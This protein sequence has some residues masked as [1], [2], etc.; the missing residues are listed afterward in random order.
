MGTEAGLRTL[1]PQPPWAASLCCSLTPHPSLNPC[2]NPRTQTVLAG[3]EATDSLLSLTPISHVFLFAPAQS[4]QTGSAP[5]EEKI[6]CLTQ[7]RTVAPLV[8]AARSAQHRLLP[9]SVW[10]LCS[11]RWAPPHRSPHTTLA[12]GVGS[13][14]R[15]HDHITLLLKAFQWLPVA[16]AYRP[17][18]ATWHSGPPPADGQ[19][20]IRFSYMPSP[21]HFSSAPST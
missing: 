21:F 19:D 2:P 17:C 10:L 14:K 20:V 4:S 1:K 13:F 9:Q 5:A 12:A 6:T 16:L 3:A 8:P 18:P 11:V 7:A 15:R